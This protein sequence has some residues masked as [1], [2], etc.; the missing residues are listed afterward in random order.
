MQ[1]FPSWQQGER[2]EYPVLRGAQRADVAIVG[3]GLTGLTLA[4]M[5]S[6]QGLDVALVEARRLATGNTWASTGKVTA[7]LAEVYPRI[8]Q[9][10][11]LEA[12]GTY[13]RLI[14]ESMHGVAS[15]CGAMGV[16]CAWQGISVYSRKE[17]DDAQLSEIFQAEKNIG[18]PVQ[19][20]GDVGDCPIPVARAI[21]MQQ[22][23]LVVEPV[24]YALALARLASQRG[25]RI[26]ENSPVRRM[27]GLRLYTPGGHIEA[28]HVVLATGYPLGTLHLPLLGMLEQRLGV[29]RVLWGGAPFH[30]SHLAA[31]ENGLN[32]RP[33]GD[34]RM[35][36]SC[37]LSR[38]GERGLE[39]RFRRLNWQ[40][41]RLLRD[42]QQTED[43]TRQDVWSEDGLPLIGPVSREDGRTLIAT[44]YSGWG[45]ANS[46]LAGRILTGDLLGKPLAEA[47]LFEPARKYPGRLLATMKGSAKSAG[48]LAAGLM[49]FGAPIC[50]HMG[51]RLR[52]DLEERQWECPCHGSTFTVLGETTHGPA[53]KDANVSRRQR[54]DA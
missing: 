54:P 17:E 40:Q 37:E 36:L 18:L 5:L 38:V 53:I 45:V 24:R 14:H 16:P 1:A 51:C 19:R 46:F 42:W 2:D 21:H 47:A 20:S 31:A 28:L 8:A 34:G 22:E 7:Q 35:L 25:C 11:G 26:W 10:V 52:Y 50:P 23:Q 4:A 48:A 49:R 13:A 6:G 15:L 12:A 41:Q 29:T 43:I 3:G 39:E 30:M 27:E 44:G 9:T 33:L 32:F